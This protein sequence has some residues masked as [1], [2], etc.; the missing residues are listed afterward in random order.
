M[1]ETM[2]KTSKFCF[3]F[4]LYIFSCSFVSRFDQVKEI[5]LVDFEW[6][7]FFSTQ[8]ISAQPQK[9][10]NPGLYILL[11]FEWNRWNKWSWQLISY[12]T[13]TFI[14]PLY[15]LIGILKVE[16]LVLTVSMV[17][18]CI[19]VWL[20]WNLSRKAAMLCSGCNITGFVKFNICWYIRNEL[21]ISM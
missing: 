9:N 4:T 2:S 3:G 13:P 19:C 11:I 10:G 21:K 14:R 5:I 7:I 8:L 18:K 20:G 16:A 12:V 1:P 6:Q 17:L 15:T